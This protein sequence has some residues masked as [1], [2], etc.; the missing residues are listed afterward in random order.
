MVQIFSVV[1][2]TQRPL[3]AC[4][5]VLALAVYWTMYRRASRAPGKGPNI[6]HWLPYGCGVALLAAALL[7]PL[8]EAADHILWAH[9][10]QHVLL[11]DIAPA[12]LL[13][14]VRAPILPLGLGRGAL[15]FVARKGTAGAVFEVLK[16]PWVALPLWAICQWVWSYPPLFQAAN[17]SEPLHLLEH[18][19]LFYSG[20][21]LWWVVVD[22]L[23]SERQRP[24][25]GRL[26]V[27]GFSRIATATICLP[28]TFLSTTLYPGYAQIAHR[29]GRSPLTDQQLA[30]ASMCF[31][32]L[33]VFGIAFAVVLLDALGREERAFELSSRASNRPAG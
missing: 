23:P 19:S 24:R 4:T 11:S 16:S 10:L 1:G 25:M 17:V 30:G 2:F 13:I 6:T 20:I 7:S 3:A 28:M 27:L 26:A 32:E 14:G 5:V 33:L 9:T 21:F 31:I 8:V 15:R 22:P 29:A 12:L 18:A